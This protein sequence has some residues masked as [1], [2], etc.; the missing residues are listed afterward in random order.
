MD[1][2]QIRLDELGDLRVSETPPHSHVE[3]LALPEFSGASEMECHGLNGG[4]GEDTSEFLSVYDGPHSPRW[5]P[6]TAGIGDRW[7]FGRVGS[8]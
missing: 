6:L 7:S 5:K 3:V 2:Y 1:R 4:G 8:P